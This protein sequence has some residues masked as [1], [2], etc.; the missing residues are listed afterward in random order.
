MVGLRSASCRALP[1]RI[2]NARPPAHIPSMDS[3]APEPKTAGRKR[4][5]QA[6]AFF[7]G[8]EIQRPAV[9]PTTPLWRIERGAKIAVQQYADELAAKK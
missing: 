8:V 6:K 1:V 7:L 9:P 3:P 4:T 5:R 2:A